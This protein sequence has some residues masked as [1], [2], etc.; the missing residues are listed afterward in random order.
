[1]EQLDLMVKE[2]NKQ[3]MLDASGYHDLTDQEEILHILGLIL[4]MPYLPCI[5]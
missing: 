4:L 2:T 1:M 3:I 5:P